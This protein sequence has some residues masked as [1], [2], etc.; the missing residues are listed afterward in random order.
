MERQR[1]IALAVSGLAFLG[2]GGLLAVAEL[3]WW[4]KTAKALGDSELT[5]EE[6]RARAKTFRRMAEMFKDNMVQHQVNLQIA[7]EHEREI[8]KHRRMQLWWAAA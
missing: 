7:A 1:Y 4:Q 2:V 5:V 8:R 6:H 3:G